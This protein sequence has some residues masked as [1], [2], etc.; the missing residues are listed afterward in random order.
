MKCTFWLT[1]VRSGENQSA[2][3]RKRRHR[4]PSWNVTTIRF[5]R[6]PQ[7]CQPQ[8]TR[9]GAIALHNPFVVGLVGIVA[10]LRQAV[11]DAIV[12]FQM[13]EGFL[14]R[15]PRVLE[16]CDITLPGEYV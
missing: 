6:R 10:A 12:L 8:S 14:H 5:M 2:R 15:R 1:A 13:G 9:V 4:L 16:K 11:S 7:R 3:D